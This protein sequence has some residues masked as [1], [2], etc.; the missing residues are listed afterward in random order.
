MRDFFS[1]HS[2][3]MEISLNSSGFTE[4]LIE[5]PEG[6]LFI[7]SPHYQTLRSPCFSEQS[8]LRKLD[9]CSIRSI[10]GDVGLPVE[11]H[12]VKMKELVQSSH[13]QYSGLNL[14]GYRV[15]QGRFGS[16]EDSSLLEAVVQSGFD[17]NKCVRVVAEGYESVHSFARALSE[18][19]LNSSVALQLKQVS[20]LSP[21]D[22]ADK[23]VCVIEAVY[24][25][26]PR[27]IHLAKTYVGISVSERS[28]MDAS[29][30]AACNLVGQILQTYQP[31]GFVV[32]LPTQVLSEKLSPCLE[33][34]VYID[35]PLPKKKGF[36]R[37]LFVCD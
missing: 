36:F 28:A 31:E 15:H 10:S 21:D 35:A 1:G 26:I 5:T 20:V 8:P 13:I 11:I 34:A 6:S 16:N 9:M 4:Y 7:P 27:F 17:N 2:S 32:P 25:A 19:F 37:K 29:L 3:C 30:S 18:E 24:P 33:R 14:A 12:S 22:S 23:Y